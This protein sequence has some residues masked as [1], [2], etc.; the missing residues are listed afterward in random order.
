MMQVSINLLI[1]SLFYCI[2]K[3]NILLCSAQPASIFLLNK[4][5]YSNPPLEQQNVFVL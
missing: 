3:N 2:F 5:Q 1:Q 4:I